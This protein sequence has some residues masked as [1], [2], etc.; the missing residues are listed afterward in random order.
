MAVTC[1]TAAVGAPGLMVAEIPQ[2][3]SH[4]VLHGVGGSEQGLAVRL[5]P[6]FAH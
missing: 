4:L 2:A 6:A 5:D 1:A 3:V